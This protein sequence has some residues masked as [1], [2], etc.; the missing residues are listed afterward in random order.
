MS[1]TAH[2]SAYFIIPG[3]PATAGYALPSRYLAFVSIALHVTA[4]YLVENT[5]RAKAQWQYEMAVVL[6]GGK[7]STFF[8]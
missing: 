6:L 1:N 8:Y 3:V 4:D 7:Y 5:A 2:K